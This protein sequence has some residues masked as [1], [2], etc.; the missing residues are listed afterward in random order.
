MAVWSS[1]S[2]RF[3]AVSGRLDAE[4]FRPEDL[5]RREDLLADGGIELGEIA[6]VL[7]GQP[8]T[9]YAEG[10]V[11]VV[12]AGDLVAS[13]IYPRCGRPFLRTRAEKGQ[14]RIVKRDVLVS[15]IGVGS[16]GKISLVIDAGS[17]VTVPEVTVVRSDTV[18]PEFFFAYL[19]SAGGQAQIE[20][21]VTGGTGQ[22]HLRKATVEG[23]IIP[24]MPA[25]A[26]T[27]LRAAVA[28]AYEAERCCRRA[29]EEAVQAM[30]SVVGESGARPAG[31]RGAF[32]TGKELDAADP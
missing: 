9:Y 15:S 24:R 6:T 2:A 4:Y 7:N 19:A 28:E 29:Y 1:A 20:R 27:R 22:Q 32:G 31:I 23:L 16:I 21:E 18:A 26:E 30:Q 3:A 11:G 8:V 25:G 10:D 13:L 14:I 17:L 5:R 12:R